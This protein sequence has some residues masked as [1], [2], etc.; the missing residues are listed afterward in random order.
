M[1]IRDLR[2]LEALAVTFSAAV[3]VLALALLAMRL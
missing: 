3:L 2:S 1:K